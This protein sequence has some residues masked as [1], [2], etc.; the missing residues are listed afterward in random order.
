MS[1]MGLY[2]SP[3]Q[4][5]K[6]ILASPNLSGNIFKLRETPNNI[7]N[8]SKYKYLVILAK[9]QNYGHI[10]NIRIIRMQFSSRVSINDLMKM[11]CGKSRLKV[12]SVPVETQLY[13]SLKYHK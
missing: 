13:T 12:K 6:N 4:N 11:G 9:S 8:Q 1:G 3:C 10:L 7:Q 5:Q 2:N